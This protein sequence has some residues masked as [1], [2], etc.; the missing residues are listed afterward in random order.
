MFIFILTGCSPKGQ[1]PLLFR[2]S[3]NKVP[4]EKKIAFEVPEIKLVNCFYASIGKNK[5]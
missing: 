2:K 5:H 1:F 3:L 4:E